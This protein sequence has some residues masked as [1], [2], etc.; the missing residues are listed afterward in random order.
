MPPSSV[1]GF[2]L[3]QHRVSGGMYVNVFFEVMT[4]E[5]MRSGARL[6]CAFMSL[7]AF[8][9]APFIWKPLGGSTA[10]ASPTRKKKHI[11]LRVRSPDNPP[12]RSR[13]S[14]PGCDRAPCLLETFLVALARSLRLECVPPGGLQVCLKRT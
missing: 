7:S 14:I 10:P 12:G 3:L 9:C 2:E 1:L 6:R 13:V 4:A 5:Q 8:F 11:S